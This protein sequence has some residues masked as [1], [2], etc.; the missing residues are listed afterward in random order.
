MA[1]VAIWVP[2][3]VIA[4]AYARPPLLT[5]AG[6][7]AIPERLD[8]VFGDRME[9]LGFEL[10]AE[11]IR[12]GDDLELTIYWRARAPMSH[13]YSVFVHLLEAN[14]LTISQRDT[15]PGRGLFPTTLWKPGDAIA[16][17]YL[18][19]VPAN[20]F[21]PN[22][23]TVEV[24]LYS[25]ESGERLPVRDREGRDLGDSVRLRQVLLRAAPKDGLA[26][27]VEFNL[28]NQVALVGYDL[29]RTALR[30]GDTLQLTL[31]WQAL[32]PLKHDYT[33]FARVFDALGNPWAGT[34]GQPFRGHSPTSSWRPGQVIQDAH[35][36]VLPPDIPEGA[37]YL[38]AGMYQA[39]TLEYL[40]LRG[41]WGHVEESP[42]ILT[43]IRVLPPIQAEEEPRF[44]LPSIQY[45]LDVAFGEV[46]RLKGFSLDQQ[47]V[48]PHERLRLT[49]YWEAI[50]EDAPLVSHTVFTHLV[51]AGGRIVAQHDG[52]PA[53]GAWPTTA[54][55]R[56]QVIVDRHHLAFVDL[57]YAGEGTLIVG[58]YDP[59]SMQRVMTS[60]GDDKVILPVRVDVRP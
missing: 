48:N 43:R 42:A 23:L 9:L 12:P 38:E 3:G 51:D 26:N 53:S 58:L 24:G 7:E 27:P 1:T 22:Q 50:N 33:V 47:A 52:P 35:E 34:A 11:E 19:R 59:E 41:R 21:N 17:T 49:L 5:P 36:L 46:A 2:F 15:Y 37:Y 60:D 31:Y 4:P 54:W 16:D 29:D 14:D 10:A 25:L 55:T 39:E 40:S 8:L 6:Q 45:P 20:T 44:D 13:N 32:A 18:I 30:P 56:G 28:D 57:G